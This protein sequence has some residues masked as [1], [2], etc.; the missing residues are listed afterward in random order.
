MEP[1]P[2]PLCL[3][4]DDDPDTCWAL[5]HI[6]RKQGLNTS[7]ALSGGQALEEIGQRRYAIALLDV[8]LPDMDGLELA[9][10][11]RA[12]DA[13]VAIIVVS[14]Y[15]YGDAPAI[16]EAQGGGLIQ[17]FVGKPFQHAEI[18]RAVSAT[19]TRAASAR[20]ALPVSA[21]VERREKGV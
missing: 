1:G 2:E 14:G 8:K 15:F 18:V 12:M 11:I 17:G 9:R 16:R 7:R 4:V 3:I 10:R 21:A 13:C 19:L 6:L 5:E 20:L